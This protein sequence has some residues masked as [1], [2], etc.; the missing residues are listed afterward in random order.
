MKRTVMLSCAIG[1]SIALFAL[2]SLFLS[3]YT[4][5][6]REVPWAVPLIRFQEAG[7]RASARAFPCKFEGGWDTGCEMYKTVPLIIATNAILYSA[8]IVSFLHLYRTRRKV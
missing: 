5:Q 8:L 7:Y 2:L 4:F 1:T 3:D 6:S